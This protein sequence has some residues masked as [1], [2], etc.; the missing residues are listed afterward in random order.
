VGYKNVGMSFGCLSYM[1]FCEPAM[2]RFE[3]P[4]PYRGQGGGGATIATKKNYK[5][6]KYNK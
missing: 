3:I 1:G 5:S 6:R 2:L 4:F